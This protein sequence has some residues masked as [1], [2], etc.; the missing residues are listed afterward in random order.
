MTKP[1]KRTLIFVSATLIVSSLIMGLWLCIPVYIEKRVLPELCK[2]AGVELL[3]GHVRHFGMT[4]A[5]IGVLAIKIDNSR[6]FSTHT[7]KLNYSLTAL[8]RNQIAVLTLSDLLLEI[9]CE[10]NQIK[11]NGVLLPDKRSLYRSLRPS[12]RDS[13][14]KKIPIGIGR[15]VLLPSKA[16][17]NYGNN[18]WT[19]PFDL[20]LTKINIRYGEMAGTGGVDINGSRF[21][22]TAS[23]I[24]HLKKLNLSITGKKIQLDKFTNFFNNLL[25]IQASGTADF[26]LK[27]SLLPEVN[28]LQDSDLLVHF[29]EAEIKIAEYSIAVRSGKS[30][31]E[32]PLKLH[33]KSDRTSYWE[34][35]A[36]GAQVVSPFKARIDE[37]KGSI[38]R[39]QKNYYVDTVIRS[40]MEKLFPK[41]N[42][43]GQQA[44]FE[45]AKPVAVD[46]NLTAENS[47]KK[48]L[49][50]SLNQSRNT[51]DPALKI[52]GV[53]FG[54][55]LM[56]EITAISSNAQLIKKNLH[57]RTNIKFKNMAVF[58]PGGNFE[59]LGTKAD[60]KLNLD[61]SSPT[62]KVLA[63]A[64]TVISTMHLDA[65][66][67]KTSYR[68]LRFICDIN[69]HKDKSWIVNTRTHIDGIWVK[70]R[71]DRRLRLGR[72][73]INLP[74][75]L[76]KGSDNREGHMKVASISWNQKPVGSLQGPLHQEEN[77]FVFNGRYSKKLPSRSS[78]PLPIDIVGNISN[79]GFQMLWYAPHRRPTTMHQLPGFNLSFAG[80]NLIGSISKDYLFGEIVG[81]FP[82][83]QTN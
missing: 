2:K 11:V 52:R 66:T 76:S 53:L 22:F 4:E 13:L 24:H 12:N 78:L 44:L 10:K 30:S 9:D 69:N 50:W 29:N 36:T 14:K 70:I 59:S 45:L 82:A 81:V 28:L 49:H 60:L 41:E 25:P 32:Q 17:L 61:L 56:A 80:M 79:N 43:A 54:R 73:D 42:N 35:A 34:L 27:V 67:I 75:Q 8:V 6:I 57:T 40:H 31:K 46:W 48:G 58:L 18:S 16:I 63:N 38:R 19:M 72:I 33:L 1:L 55:P 7:V 71:K 23:L 15:I 21:S 68:G 51:T 47:I 3:S 39:I 37:I 64:D 77:N 5:Q 26:Q 83:K 62:M 65:N 74:V 20:D